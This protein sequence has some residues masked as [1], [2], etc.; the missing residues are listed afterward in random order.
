MSKPVIEAPAKTAMAVV[1]S[2]CPAAIVIG[3]SAIQEFLVEARDG[4]ALARRNMLGVLKAETAQIGQ[5]AAPAAFV[6]G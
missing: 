4:A 2:E 6:L 5:R 1:R 3:T